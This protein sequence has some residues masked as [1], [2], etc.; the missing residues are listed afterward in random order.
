VE[1][2]AESLVIPTTEIKPQAVLDI[3]TSPKPTNNEISE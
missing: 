1:N 3:E 2:K